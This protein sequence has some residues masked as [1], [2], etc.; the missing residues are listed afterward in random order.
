MS[1]AMRARVL[2]LALLGVACLSPSASAQDSR[3]SG[4]IKYEYVPPMSLR[5]VA[6]AERLKQFRILEQLSEFFSPIRLPHSFTMQTSECGA[7]NAF[8]SA[9]QRRIV[10]CYELVESVERVAPKAGEASDFT[11][12]EVVAGALVGVLLHELGHAVFDMSEVPVIGR[13]E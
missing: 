11:Y 2:V 7:V 10:L 8:Y 5:Y 13:E 1:L 6:T 12:Q 9:N 3:D 4:N